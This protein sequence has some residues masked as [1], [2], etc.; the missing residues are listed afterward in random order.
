MNRPEAHGRLKRQRRGS[1][2]RIQVIFTYVNRGTRWQTR[3][4]FI[5]QEGRP[6]IHGIET[7]RLNGAVTCNLTLNFY[8]KTKATN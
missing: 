3:C 2:M 5:P 7:A 1:Y 8:H 6:A 4:M